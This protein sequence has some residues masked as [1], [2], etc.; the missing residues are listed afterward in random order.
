M[1][2][3][4]SQRKFWIHP[5]TSIYSEFLYIVYIFILFIFSLK[6]AHMKK[7]NTQYENWSQIDE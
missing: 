7:S 4:P 3:R 1:E 2:Y 6:V 5:K